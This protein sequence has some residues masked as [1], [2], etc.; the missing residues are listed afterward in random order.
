M[1]ARPLPSDGKIRDTA[2]LW[3]KT[4]LGWF[5]DFREGNY[6]MIPPPAFPQEAFRLGM[7]LKRDAADQ[8]LHGTHSHTLTARLRRQALLLH[9]RTIRRTF[10]LPDTENQ[11]PCQKISAGADLRSASFSCPD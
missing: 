5:L 7:G 6:L 11:I 2:P 4:A 3:Q 1:R 8:T 10:Q 9:V